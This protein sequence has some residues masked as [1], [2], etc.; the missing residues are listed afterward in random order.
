MKREEIRR[1]RLRLGL[2]QVQLAEKLHCS[3][4]TVNNWE[5]G[6]HEPRGV[7][8]FSLEDLRRKAAKMK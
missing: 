2:T 1:L 6:R 7:F 8:L 4:Q 5:N 3:F